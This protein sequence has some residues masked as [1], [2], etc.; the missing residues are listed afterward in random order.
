MWRRRDYTDERGRRV[1]R[2][3][4]RRTTIDALLI[5]AVYLL[6]CASED[7]EIREKSLDVADAR[8][9]RRRRARRRTPSSCTPGSAKAGDVGAGDRARRRGDRARR[10]PRPSAARC[11]SRTPPAPAGRS[12]ARSR[13]W[14]ALIDA[15]GGGERLGVCLDSCHLYASRLRHPHAPR[16]WPRCSTTATRG[17]A[18]AAGLAARQRLQTRSA[19]TRP[20]RRPR[21]RRARRR[22]L[23]GVPVR[24]ALRGPAVRPRDAAARRRSLDAPRAAQRGS[25]R[26]V[27]ATARRLSGCVKR[28]P[29]PPVQR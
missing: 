18:R 19:R 6:N 11:I 2:G 3:D 20:P 23:R 28:R 24:A 17:R 1:P 9:A 27:S 15:A 22:G 13:S 10:W 7:T 21:R 25:R 29:P 12:G 8:A 14:R 26:R 4:R 5:H 16:G